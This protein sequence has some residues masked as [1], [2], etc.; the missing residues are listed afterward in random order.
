MV[1]KQKINIYAI[2][3]YAIFPLL[4][5]A[6]YTSPKNNNIEAVISLNSITSTI[7]KKLASFEEFTR[8]YP[9]LL[10][11]I[12]FSITLLLFFI[13]IFVILAK[14]RQTKIEAKLEKSKAD[15]KAKQDFLSRMS[16]EIRTP[17]N[18]IIGITN[19]ISMNK[20]I[21]PEVTRDLEKL[22]SSAHYL[23]GL[24][25]NILDMSKI[26]QGKMELMKKAFS[27]NHMISS[28]SNMLEPEAGR[29]KVNFK[30]DCSIIH[31]VVDSDEIRLR[32]IITNLVTNAFKFS[33]NNAEVKLTIHEIDS[34][35]KTATY[36]FIVEDHGIGIPP[37]DQ[38]RVFEPF[39]QINSN[40]S[41]NIGTGL[42]LPI[43]QSIVRLMNGNIKLT[44]QKNEGCTFT[45]S[46]TFPLGILEAEAKKIAEEHLVG[47]DVLVVEDNDINAEI[48]VAFLEM[49]GAI[50]H[51][52][53]NGKEAVEEF[54]SAPNNYYSLILMD[55][56]MPV[57]DGLTATKHIRN[58][59]KSNAKE[60]PIIAMTANTFRE[61]VNNA[62][63][64]GMNDFI[65]KPID[66]QNL[67]T[68][69]GKYIKPKH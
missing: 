23:L 57:M 6:Y 51:L 31:D 44:S 60:I 33:P 45:F 41:R 61:D 43:S 28:L 65:P 29:F 64:A 38:E 25:N 63:N 50:T 27:L 53:K 30:L 58:L 14:F 59:N 56:Q 69:L 3:S 19:M 48:I 26:D 20:N 4:F 54:K 40:I 66:I 49:K 13:I 52:M 1:K 18:A 2:H 68:I 37:E 24:I 46:L 22:H 10:F 67:Y 7:T 55:I 34:N 9:M 11:S 62:M 32:Q 36:Q 16:H 39:E 17:M 12:L 15:N 47:K 21:P 42:G 8:D 35:D 5:L